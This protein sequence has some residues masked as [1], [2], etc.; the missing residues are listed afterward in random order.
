MKIFSYSM[1]LIFIYLWGF[2][3]TLN[4]PLN[5]LS[6]VRKWINSLLMIYNCVHFLHNSYFDIW[7]TNVYCWAI[8]L[9]LYCTRWNDRYYLKLNKNFGFMYS[10]WLNFEIGDFFWIEDCFLYLILIL[11][12]IWS[13]MRLIYVNHCIIDMG[14]SQL[15]KKYMGDWK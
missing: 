6:I 2:L 5:Y 10:F 3:P 11:P 13:C 14:L 4:I 7:N 1:K 15:N 8:F 9:I 12:I